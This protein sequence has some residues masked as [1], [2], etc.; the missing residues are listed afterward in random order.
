MESV[1]I[2]LQNKKDTT[3]SVTLDVLFKAVLTISI[4]LGTS[5]HFFSY[6]A[7]GLAVIYFFFAE[8]EKCINCMFFLMPFANVFKSDSTASS[9]FWYLTIVLVIKLLLSKGS[10]D[11]KFFLIWVVTIGLQAVGCRG[12]FSLFVKQAVTLL[13][14]YG[15]FHSCKVNAKP[16]VLNWT[17]G[18][19]VSCIIANMPGIFDG[20]QEYLRVVRAYDVSIDIRRFTGLYSDPNYL[21]QALVMLC[22]ALFTLIQQKR[23]SARNWAWIILLGVFGVSTLSKSFFLMLFVF[24]F[25]FVIVA[26]KQRNSRILSA[27]FLV[28]LAGIGLFFAGKLTTVENILIRFSKG[29]IT[30]GRVEIWKTYIERMISYPWNLCFG[31][32]VESMLEVVPH[33]TI[34][35]FLY[36][37]GIFGT[38]V[39]LVGFLCALGG[40]IRYTGMLREIPLFC[41][42]MTSFFLSNL[43]MFDFAYYLI[44]IMAFLLE[45]TAVE[46]KKEIRGAYGNSS[47]SVS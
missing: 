13:L 4:L 39:Y 11:K 27:V 37:Y 41:I 35:D 32:G 42:M 9:L 19:I 8:N 21:S 22:G 47:Y 44:L 24:A 38:I 30:T 1:E 36:S 16:L 20:V 15:Y 26:L 17:A 31:F 43:L 34:L 6:F 14:I 3:K 29:E 10:I 18:M 40:K 12:Q 45:E 2:M 25:L 5:V 33:N 23:I 7:F 46:E 28:F